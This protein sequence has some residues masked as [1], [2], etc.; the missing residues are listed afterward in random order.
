MAADGVCP[1][2]L[3]NLRPIKLKH[4][5]GVKA[6]KSRHMNKPILA[7]IARLRLLVGFLGEKSQFNWWPS[8]FFTP[9]SRAFLS[10]IFS[11]TVF[12]AQY[13]GVKEAASRVHDERIG[14]GT[15][16]H[17]FRLPENVE[18]ALFN[19]LHDPQFADPLGVPLQEKAQAL[20]SLA[21]LADASPEHREGPVLI[22][23]IDELITG[24]NL[25]ILAHHYRSAFARGTEA[26]PYYVGKK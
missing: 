16:Y 4:I 25:G 8:S 23:D 7:Q 6:E 21:T 19:S 15:V 2:L 11:K 17:L 5:E 3:L 20:E 26:Y 9:S 13:Q 12:I 22:G 14:V 24:R 1:T 18:Q 10:P